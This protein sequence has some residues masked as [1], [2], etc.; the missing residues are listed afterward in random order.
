MVFFVLFKLLVFFHR[1]KQTHII[2]LS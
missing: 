2:W 1:F